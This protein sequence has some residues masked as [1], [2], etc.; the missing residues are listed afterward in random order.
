M[1]T[2]AKKR[3]T[4]EP[5]PVLEEIKIEKPQIFAMEFKNDNKKEEHV[6][7]DCFSSPQMYV[8]FGESENIIEVALVKA[9]A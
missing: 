5:I 2:A 6:A 1:C 4:E 9:A 8:Y 3:I 7:I